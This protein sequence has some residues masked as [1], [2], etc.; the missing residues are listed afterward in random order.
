[1]GSSF[2]Q[3]LWFGTALIAFGVI[4]NISAGF[5]HVKLIRQLDHGTAVRPRFPYQAVLMAL[6]LALVGIGMTIY[7]ISVR[8]SNHT[9]ANPNLEGNMAITKDSEIVD[10]RSHHSVNETVNR[11]Q[12]LLESKGATLFALVD[13]SGEA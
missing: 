12:H 6:F 3:S 7:L 4:V 13:H 1:M 2:G 10:I 8:A 9:G 5:H 11:L